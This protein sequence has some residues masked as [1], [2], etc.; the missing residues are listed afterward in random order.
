MVTRGFINKEI[1][2]LQKSI[3]DL[4]EKYGYTGSA[5]TLKT[6]EHHE[7]MMHCLQYALAHKSDMDEGYRIFSISAKALR[8]TYSEII[9]SDISADEKF[10]K[11]EK[12]IYGMS[13]WKSQDGKAR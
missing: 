1:E 9:N 12:A 6:I 8:E 11:I 7:D 4:R 13:Y 10:T 5:S 2:K 3:D